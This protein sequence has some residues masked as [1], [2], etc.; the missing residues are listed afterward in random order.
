MATPPR[1]IDQLHAYMAAG[2]WPRALALAARFPRL[3]PHRD[4]IVR[5]HEALVHPRFYAQVGRDPLAA[6]TAGIAALRARYRHDGTS[7]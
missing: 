2:D 4:A 7:G 3:G 1:K 6:V 5:G